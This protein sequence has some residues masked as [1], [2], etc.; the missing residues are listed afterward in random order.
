MS[1][2]SIPKCSSTPAT[3]S[4]SI[5]LRLT[6]CRAIVVVLHGGGFR[7]GSNRDSLY[8]GRWLASV[9]DVV[10]AVPNYRLGPLGFLRS[11]DKPDAPGNQGLW[12]QLLALQWV[13]TNAASF[14]AHQD[15]VT[16]LGVDSGAVAAGLHLLSPL[17]RQFFE[18]AVLSGGSPFIMSR[19]SAF[20]ESEE[21]RQLA[22]TACDEPHLNVAVDK[23]E[24]PLGQSAMA[25]LRFASAEHIVNSL[26]EFN[27]VHGRP[28]GPLY[29][30]NMTED[31]FFLPASGES[32]LPDEEG[33][34][35]TFGGK[36]LLIGYAVNE[37]EYFL[38][39]FIDDW[40]LE[41][42]D[43]LPK[44][45]VRML[46]DRLVLH[47]FGAEQLAEIG[48]PYF[49]D[50]LAVNAS[51]FSSAEDACVRAAAFLGDVLVKCPARMMADLASEGGARVYFYEFDY[52]LNE[53]AMDDSA[54][55]H[56]HWSGAPHYADALFMLGIFLSR[57]LPD[58]SHALA[59]SR[60]MMGK[61]GAFARTG[62]ANL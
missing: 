47:F 17:S 18:R 24:Q 35:G 26:D 22:A 32:L 60:R 29:G 10:V 33:V 54:E 57:Q 45:M 30:A 21:L 36:A 42:V 2:Q 25:C 50:L 56:G 28:F 13:R 52:N 34:G 7:T 27:G 3:G 49:G 55:V 4:I 9:A 44:P 11:G 16:L 23:D 20:A 61:L 41:T 39:Q 38:R 48:R 31:D 8:D 59:T 37:G 5:P 12:D 14:G 51:S 58:N 19:F 15:D 62:Y 53:L 1:S 46:L 6:L 43:A 40:D